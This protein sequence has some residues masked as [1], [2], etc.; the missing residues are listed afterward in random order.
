MDAAKI[1]VTQTMS[2]AVVERG[3][4]V[5]KRVKTR[6]RNQLNNGT[7]WTCLHVSINRPEPKSED[8]QVILAEAAQVWRKTHKRNLPPLSLPRIGGSKQRDVRTLKQQ[9]LTFRLR[10]LESVTGNNF[11][12]SPN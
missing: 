11:K 9:L 6:L 5:V 3:A 8:C 7:L 1:C 10:H 12:H 2:N 4:S